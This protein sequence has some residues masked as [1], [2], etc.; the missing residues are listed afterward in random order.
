MFLLKT[1]DDIKSDFILK[2]WNRFAV[3]LKLKKVRGN[4]SERF[5]RLSYL[6]SKYNEA[7]LRLFFRNLSKSG[8]L[9]NK[10]WFNI[11]WCLDESHFVSILEGKY[12]GTSKEQQFSGGSC[13]NYN[14]ERL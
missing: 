14:R 5:E 7:D 4:T 1:D 12:V 3:K 9:L 2:L 10:H 8:F 11:D 13:V 6:I